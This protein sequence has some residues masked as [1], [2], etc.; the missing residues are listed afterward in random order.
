MDW[1]GLSTK[2]L[3]FKK[4]FGQPRLLH[5]ACSGYRGHYRILCSW[6]HW[7]IASQPSSPL[8]FSFAINLFPQTWRCLRQSIYRA[9]FHLLRD[10]LFHLVQCLH[11]TLES[12]PVSEILPLTLLF[13]LGWVWFALSHWQREIKPLFIPP[14]SNMVLLSVPSSITEF[15]VQ[16]SMSRIVACFPDALREPLIVL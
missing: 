6:A 7:G 12:L 5:T 3:L 1:I 10:S 11:N 13:W 9:S 16:I 2:F 8:G 4:A 14:L 15:C